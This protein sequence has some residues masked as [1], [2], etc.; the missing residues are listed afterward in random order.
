VKCMGLPYHWPRPTA[1]HCG[2]FIWF[3]LNFSSMKMK[4]SVY[5]GILFFSDYF[6]DIVMSIVLFGLFASFCL[7]VLYLFLPIGN[8]IPWLHCLITKNIEM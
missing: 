5:I 6:C 3:T 2:M 7:E 4:A 8:W 1:C